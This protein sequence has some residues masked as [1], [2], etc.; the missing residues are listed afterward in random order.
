MVHS[1]IDGYSRLPVYCCCATNNRSDTVLSCFLQADQQ[2]GLPSR[3]RCDRGTE[4]Y[5]V[6]Y[7][8][9]THPLRGTARGSIICGRSVHNQRIERFWRYIFVGC[10]C[11]FYYTFYHM[12]DSGLLV[13]D[14]PVHLW[15]L[16]YVYLP[17]IN[18]AIDTFV[19]AWAHHPM[20]SERNMTPSQLW[21]Q[22]MM[23][24]HD[25]GL[26][27]TEELYESSHMVSNDVWSASESNF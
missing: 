25:S 6:G 9:L 13:H 2:C 24:N 11:I 26:C 20:S 1:G 23:E 10:L 18:Y 19:Q 7:Y 14:D 15:C 3:V 16:H 21:I 27:V 4:N 8:M 12:E 17:Y 22:G 5:G